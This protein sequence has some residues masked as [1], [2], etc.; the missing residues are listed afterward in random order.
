MVHDFFLQTDIKVKGK[1]YEIF[2]T[3][4]YILNLKGDVDKFLIM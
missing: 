3:E 1:C 2:Q 4:K